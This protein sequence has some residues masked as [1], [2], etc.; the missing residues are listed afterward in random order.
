MD[1]PL[2]ASQ[3]GWE[4][5]FVEVFGKCGGGFGACG[6]AIPACGDRIFACE[7]SLRECDKLFGGRKKCFGGCVEGI[8]ASL[9]LLIV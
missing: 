6:G 9:F 1:F 5:V 3:A 2:A 8:N 7:K 4:D